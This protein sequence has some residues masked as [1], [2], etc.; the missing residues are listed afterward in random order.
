MTRVDNGMTLPNMSALLS[1]QIK[2]CEDGG[3]RTRIWLSRH[4]WKK[5]ITCDLVDALD[6]ISRE[7]G[8][9]IAIAAIDYT[10]LKLKSSSLTMDKPHLAT[11]L[12]IHDYERG[13]VSSLST[14]LP[15]KPEAA[16][17]L[18]C[19]KARIP[20]LPPSLGFIQGA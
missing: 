16:P 13:E 2:G 4:Y 14:M 6:D 20:C 18:S 7:I 12:W 1:T 10:R 9:Y 19:R 8:N 11:R 3:R 5:W 15:G 17:A